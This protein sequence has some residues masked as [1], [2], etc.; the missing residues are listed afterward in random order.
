MQI[1]LFLRFQNAV[2]IFCLIILTNPAAKVGKIRTTKKKLCFMT[3]ENKNN[4][5]EKNMFWK[6]LE[7][8]FHSPFFGVRWSS[9]RAK[10]GA[11]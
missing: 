3:I 11:F 2:T 10:G 7:S 5:Q 8:I 6:F 9:Q 4:S 1:L